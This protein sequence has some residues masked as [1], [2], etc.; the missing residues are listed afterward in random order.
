MDPLTAVDFG[1][2]ELP[3]VKAVMDQR[4]PEFRRASILWAVERL[5]Q[6][7]ATVSVTDG[8]GGEPLLVLGVPQHAQVQ[9]GIVG[10][11]FLDLKLTMS[12]LLREQLVEQLSTRRDQR[13]ATADAEDAAK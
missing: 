9:V 11:L 2:T 1:I 13:A 5:R 4:T 3:R 12:V 7:D 10:L 8:E 6:A